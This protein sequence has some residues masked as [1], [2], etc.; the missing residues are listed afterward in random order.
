L[1]RWYNEGYAQ[2]Y[3]SISQKTRS[4]NLSPKRRQIKVLPNKLA[5]YFFIE[6]GL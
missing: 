1:I 6:C 3:L 4:N 2:G 5:S